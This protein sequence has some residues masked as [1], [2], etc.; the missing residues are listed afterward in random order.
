MSLCYRFSCTAFDNLVA[1]A[2]FKFFWC[3]PLQDVS[4]VMVEHRIRIT[5]HM[6][7][8]KCVSMNVMYLFIAMLFVYP[9]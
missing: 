6:S 7:V 8:G 5:Q 1:K 4:H 9:Q 3:P 2:K